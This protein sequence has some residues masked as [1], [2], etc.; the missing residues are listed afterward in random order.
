MK[1]YPIYE[2]IITSNDEYKIDS[3]MNG[4]ISEAEFFNSL[5]QLHEGVGDKLINFVGKTVNKLKSYFNDLKKYGNK[6][7]KVL[8]WLI[9][10][11]KSLHDKYPNLIKALVILTV[12]VSLVMVST[13]S[14]AAG[15]EPINIDP[16]YLNIVLGYANDTNVDV[17][18]LAMLIDAKDGVVDSTEWNAN[19]INNTFEHLRREM[20]EVLNNMKNKGNTTG[21]VYTLLD[22]FKEM[23]DKLVGYTIEDITTTGVDGKVNFTSKTTQ[24]FSKQ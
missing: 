6:I 16:E 14:M 20:A 17:Q 8:T 24:I 22:M 9:G 13:A 18:S 3:Y 10:K 19:D 7:G 4:T 21:D 12:M 15:G 11:I 2:N 1:L 23:G 5:E